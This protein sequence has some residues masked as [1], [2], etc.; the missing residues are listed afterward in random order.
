MACRRQGDKSLSEPIMVTLLMYICVT[1]PQSVNTRIFIYDS[2]LE[3]LV[4]SWIT[5][6]VL[7]KYAFITVVVFSNEMCLLFSL[8]LIVFMTPLLALCLVVR[9]PLDVAFQLVYIH[10][11]C[12]TKEFHLYMWGLHYQ[13]IS[14]LKSLFVIED[15]HTW[16]LI[17]WQH[18]CQ[19]KILFSSG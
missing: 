8:K 14:I 2:Y 5:C 4:T 13:E 15:F 3:V 9:D 7:R 11:D 17:G 1:Q 12:V 16:H 18:N 10:E 19:I 6:A